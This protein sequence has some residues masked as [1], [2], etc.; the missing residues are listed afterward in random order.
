MTGNDDD[1]GF[2]IDEAFGSW[3][4]R[5]KTLGLGDKGEL[6]DGIPVADFLGDDTASCQDRSFRFPFRSPSKRRQRSF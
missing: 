6:D 1:R 3:F 2:E 5:L 4:R